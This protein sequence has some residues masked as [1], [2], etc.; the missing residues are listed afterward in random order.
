MKKILLLN[1]FL[2]LNLVAISQEF[3][4]I[5]Q[6]SETKESIPGV[7]VAVLGLEKGIM[8]DNRGRFQ[9][10][11]LVQKRIVLEFSYIG[12][13]TM[14]QTVI[15]SKQNKPLVINL[16][17]TIIESH[18]VLVLRGAFTTQHQNAIKIEQISQKELDRNNGSLINALAEI[19]GADMMDAGGGAVM[20]VIR[21]L[22]MTNVLFVDNGVKLENFQ[23]SDHHPFLANQYGVA[24][25]ELVKG[26]ASLLFGSDA[27]GGV[28]HLIRE[29]QA[30]EI[31]FS[32]DW[33]NKYSS[34]AQ[35]LESNL[36]LKL[37]GK[38]AWLIVRTGI[39]NNKDYIDGSGVWVPN[40][41][42]YEKNAKIN[43]G[44]KQ[45][46]GNFNLYYDYARLRLGKSLP[47]SIPLVSSNERVPELWYQNLHNHVLNSRNVLFFGKIR[48]NSDINYQ[49]NNRRFFQ[50][51]DLAIP[52]PTNMQL[53]T[54]SA[55][56]VANI[57]FSLKS[58]LVAGTQ[59]G[60]STNRNED[61]PRKVIPDAKTNEF[62]FFWYYQHRIKETLNLQV[63]L[64]YDY[65]SLFIP[66]Q[67][68]NGALMA[69]T[70]ESD[71]LHERSMDFQ[72]VSFSAGITYEINNYLL[73][74]TNFASAYR[75]PNLAELTQK[76][77]HVNRY[78]LGNDKLQ[79][80]KNYELDASF[81]I[82]QKAFLFD[83]AVFHNDIVDYIFL[84][85]T[86]EYNS[87]G[88]FIYKYLQTNA[89]IYGGELTLSCS[90]IRNMYIDGNYSYLITKQADGSSLPFIPQNK[91][92]VEFEWSRKKCSIFDELFI[93]THL[94]YAFEHNRPS[95]FETKTDDYFLLDLSVGLN[96][97]RKKRYINVYIQLDNVLNTVFFDHLSLLKKMGYYNHGRS[98]DVGIKVGF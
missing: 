98:L 74:R 24:G 54:L 62:A 59:G 19:A 18:E 36:G 55:S 47:A 6:D 78:E 11:N 67:S 79:I 89:V 91:L 20:P 13:E 71:I 25:V 9:L 33:S 73:F 85:P 70:P 80:Q 39:K 21:G 93:N 16:K 1:L 53:N 3:N 38:N 75:A 66:L 4:G 86:S 12:Y 27:V 37:T 96:F 52:E 69:S 32:G 87:E 43:V 10:T 68:R 82:H 42:S 14:V 28:I 35:G 2:F 51:A 77:Y 81:H 17:A 44:F 65:R 76:G 7:Y 50:E 45:D 40:T 97:K 64:R 56:V 46:F 94:H 22:S 83:F 30:R 8:T 5:V 34:N 63:G 60:G 15:L 48:L 61:V 26:P 84:S 72:N 58:E 57:P 49:W 88:E 31:G 92:N 23:F 95:Q 90:P 41:R 29:K